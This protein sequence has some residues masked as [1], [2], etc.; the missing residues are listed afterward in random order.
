MINLEELILYLSILRFNSTYVDG[1]QLYDEILIYMPQLK[2]FYFSIEACV[3]NKYI[4]IDLSSNE[5]IQ[6]SFIE[7]GY[8]P[9]GSYIHSL[10]I[11]K[12]ISRCHIY[13]IPTILLFESLF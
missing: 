3:F 1:I 8:G 7:R 4:K 13:S 12:G 2:K 5:D 6:D 11:E 10:A 9:V